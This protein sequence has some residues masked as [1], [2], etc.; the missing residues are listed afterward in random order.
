MITRRALLAA[1]AA[2]VAACAVPD[3]SLATILRDGGT[4]KLPAG[5][6]VLLNQD[7]GSTT[8]IEGVPGTRLILG[9][10]GNLLRFNG[11][12]TLSN[13]TLVGNG[14]ASTPY[15]DGSAIVG[16][17][18]LELSDVTLDGFTA[19]FWIEVKGNLTARNCRFISRPGSV[20]GPQGV[21]LTQ[22]V[23]A[24]MSVTGGGA[25]LVENCAAELAHIKSLL[26]VWAGCSGV[27]R[28][29][30]VDQ[31]G[32]APGIYDD[33][34]AYVVCCYR[35]GPAARPAVLV[36]DCDF[37]GIRSA[38]IYAADAESVTCR[39]T[40][41]EGQSDT[42]GDTIPKGGIALNNVQASVI[43]ANRFENCWA[44]VSIT[45]GSTR[46]LIR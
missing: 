17:G 25:A 38:G 10:A 18:D 3:R 35:D 31:C 34:S 15:R 33:S 37:R 26:M 42:L 14:L 13:L 9:G 24:A 40:L 41:F 36:E 22:Y 8:R 28:N 39:R 20:C 1:S 46:S 27:M 4:V 21:G 32:T 45:A 23:S 11:S 6:H 19:S 44:S 2:A 7:C 5:D 30:V 43:D 12:L 16:E 29:T